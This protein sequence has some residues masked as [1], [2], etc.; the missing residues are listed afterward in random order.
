M[1]FKVILTP[2]NQSYAENKKIWL[3]LRIIIFVG[4][5]NSEVFHVP[6]PVFTTKLHGQNELVIS[7]DSEQVGAVSILLVGKKELL[8][9][10]GEWNGI[11]T[12]I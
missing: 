11:K 6:S 2:V 10:L 5:F 7:P 3:Y 1:I 8:G 4:S 12:E 9:I